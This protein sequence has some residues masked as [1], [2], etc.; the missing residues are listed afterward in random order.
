MLRIGVGVLTIVSAGCSP[1]AGMFR[2]QSQ[3]E[4]QS[5]GVALFDSSDEAQVGMIGNTCAVDTTTGLIGAD[6]DIA[7]GEEDHVQDAFGHEVVVV[8]SEGAY[9]VDRDLPAWTGGGVAIS[10]V[11]QSRLWNEGVVSLRAQNGECFVAWGDTS[12]SLGQADCGRAD[13][14]VD[15]DSGAVMVALTDRLAMVTAAGVITVEAPASFVAWD[16]V[17]GLGY[18]ASAGSS[19]VSAVGASGETRWSVTLSG[20]VRALDS[21][22]PQGAVAVMVETEDGQGEL[23]VLDGVS[24]SIVATLAT[25]TAAN[26][27]VVGN[28]GSTMAFVLPQEIHFFA[29]DLGAP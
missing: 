9:V 12:V 28:E 21:M 25:P 6:A 27:I 1:E 22:G 20:P 24:G 26:D 14:A 23:Q 17:V 3:L 10:G 13:M 4:T 29:V 18:A 15:R 5:R 16:S 8:G 19:T 2:H 7:V 11:E